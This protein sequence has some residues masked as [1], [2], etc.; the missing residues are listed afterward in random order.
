MARGIIMDNETIKKA[1]LDI[2]E[3]KID[4]TVLQSGK[5]CSRVNGLYKPDTHEIILHNG[6]FATDNQE[7]YTAVH[8]YTH[9]L[10]AEANAEK[11]LPPPGSRVHNQAFW[12]MFD[13]LIG[14]A[15]EKG[16]YKLNVEASPELQ[17]LTMKL[18]KDYIA[19]DG[20]IMQEFGRLLAR[21][22][23]L[24]DEAN[25][26]YEDYID[27]VLRLPRVAARDAERV[28]ASTVDASLG[29][30]NMKMISA[31]KDDARRADA[32]SM[33]SSGR[34]VASVRNALKTPSAELDEK[35]MLEKEKKRLERTIEQLKA[36][37]EDVEKRLEN[38]D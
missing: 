21:A 32:V 11:G 17:D 38:S 3:S 15:E 5:E 36:R 18:Q 19:R 26:R 22:H 16:Y 23:E 2:R 8:E 14:L 4:F 20:Q 1:L 35:T 13:E 7:I 25:I 9:H 24:C 10:I 33:L 37:L 27:R 6:N 31:I 34:S 30:D 12:A 29:Y 28:G